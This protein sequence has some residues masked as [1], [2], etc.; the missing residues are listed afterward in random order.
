MFLANEK[1]LLKT[2][3]LPMT[4]TAEM[5]VSPE[6]PAKTLTAPPLAVEPKVVAEVDKRT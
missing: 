5:R 3:V 6:E 2:A 1:L 4:L